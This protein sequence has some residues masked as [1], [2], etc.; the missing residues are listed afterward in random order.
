VS[1]HWAYHLPDLFL[2]VFDELREDE[3]GSS[4]FVLAQL[5]KAAGKA[6]VSIDPERAPDYYR[7]AIELSEEA[8]VA[9][10]RGVKDAAEAYILLCDGHGAG[11]SCRILC[12]QNTGARRRANRARGPAA[13]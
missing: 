12:G 2:A 8:G 11:I 3:V 6:A 10:P 9:E 5:T 13:P 4:P 1:Q 7:R